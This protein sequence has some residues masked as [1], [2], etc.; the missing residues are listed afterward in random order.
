MLD[1]LGIRKLNWTLSP[2]LADRV[3]DK[4]IVELSKINGR[5]PALSSLKKR[6]SGIYHSSCMTSK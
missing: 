3:E 1:V 2:F 6:V 5:Y 4:D